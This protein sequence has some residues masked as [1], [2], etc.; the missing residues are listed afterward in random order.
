MVFERVSASDVEAG[1]PA[2]AAGGVQG[3]QRAGGV[4]AA[5]LR[6]P[7]HTIAG[8]ATTTASLLAQVV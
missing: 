7:H 1:G 3:I 6:L 8:I 2:S 5:M 4:V